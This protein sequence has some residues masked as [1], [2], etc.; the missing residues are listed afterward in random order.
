MQPETIVTYALGSV[1]GFV[2]GLTHGTIVALG[3]LHLA[4]KVRISWRSNSA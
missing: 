4:R 3:I 2:L 1:H